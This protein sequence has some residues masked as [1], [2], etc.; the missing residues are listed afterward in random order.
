MNNIFGFLALKTCSTGVCQEFL[1]PFFEFL[2]CF[3]LLHP[4][5]L[6]FPAC[7]DK[8]FVTHECCMEFLILLQWW[9]R[10]S[11]KC[12]YQTKACVSFHWSCIFW[13]VLNTC[14]TG[15][16]WTPPE[17]YI[18]VSRKPEILPC[19]KSVCVVAWFRDTQGYSS[20]QRPWPSLIWTWKSFYFP[21]KRGSASFTHFSCGS[22]ICKGCN[23]CLN[24]I[25]WFSVQ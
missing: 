2:C 16:S 9:Q 18:C 20:L 1:E 8:L 7:S 14:N 4:C 21:F 13:L 15:R 22:R 6:K 19:I 10:S 17:L 12:V 25:F 3:L 11:S 5:S 24:Q 23:L